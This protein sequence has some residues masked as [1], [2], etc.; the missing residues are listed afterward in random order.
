[1]EE[2]EERQA[3]MVVD[4]LVVEE[5]D[6]GFTSRRTVD[7]WFIQQ[8]LEMTSAYDK[9]KIRAKPIDKW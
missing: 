7:D 2:V 6:G 1:V 5:E 3:D 4:L 9:Q 8:P